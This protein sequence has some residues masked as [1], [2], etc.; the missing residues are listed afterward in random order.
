[1]ARAKDGRANTSW[2]AWI[3]I[4]LAPLVFLSQAKSTGAA[5]KAKDR[6]AAEEKSRPESSSRESEAESEPRDESAEI[7]E[8]EAPRRISPPNE[9][10]RVTSRPLG[11]TLATT[12][13][14]LAIVL[15]LF[16]VI[17]RLARKGRPKESTTLSA[18]VVEVLGRVPLAGRQQA[19]LIRVGNKLLLVALSTGVAETLTEITDPLEVDRLC[20]LC[21]QSRPTSATAAFR[22]VLAQFSREKPG[23]SFVDT[24]SRSNESV[25]ASGPRSGFRG[26]G[27][28]NPQAFEDDQD[29]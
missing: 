12:F 6:R 26:S 13:G 16:F 5:E 25:A 23:P 18:E 29:A 24:A 22:Q 21:R 2:I 14:G 9:K 4:L 27:R 1:M 17:V 7:H 10:G 15:G 3:A 20:G 19:Q 8:A 28:S 11:G